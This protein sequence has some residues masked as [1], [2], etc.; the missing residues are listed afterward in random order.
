MNNWEQYQSTP[1]LLPPSVFERT[2]NTTSESN[3]HIVSLNANNNDNMTSNNTTTNAH[4]LM[5][6]TLTN[7]ESYLAGESQFVQ[8][9][10]ELEKLKTEIHKLHKENECLRHKN[11]GNLYTNHKKIKI[12]VVC[13]LF[14]LIACFNCCMFSKI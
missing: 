8:F 11:K 3:E 2:N 14:F 9:S 4:S 5:T 13:L 10:N 7:N 6:T 12:E 1:K